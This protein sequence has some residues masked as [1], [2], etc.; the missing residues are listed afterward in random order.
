MVIRTDATPYADL[1]RSRDAKTYTGHAIDKPEAGFFRYKL[2]S[3]SV[4][5]GVKIWFGP[6]HDPVTG[7]VLDRSH[8]WQMRL[9]DGATYC[10]DDDFWNRVWPA[11]VGDPISEVEYNQ[12][13]ARRQWAKENAP[14]SAYAKPGAKRDVL[15]MNEVLPF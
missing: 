2:R 14:D 11:C 12:L 3:G 7:E 5:G 15:S 9:D 13:C 10:W 6:P 8:R 4:A 1:S